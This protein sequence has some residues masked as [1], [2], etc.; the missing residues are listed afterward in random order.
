MTS[1]RHKNSVRRQL[2]LGVLATT[3]CALLITGAA[4]A[5]FDLRSFR[6]SALADLTAMGDILALA[7]TPALEF[8]DPQ[9]ASEY[10]ELLRAKPAITAAALYAPNGALFAK[11]SSGEATPDFP[12]LPGHDG[13]QVAGKEIALFKRV[14]ADG[15]IV[16]TVYVRAHYDVAGRIERYLGILAAVLLLSLAAA[17]LMSH[18]LHRGITEPI[19]GVVD[20]AR[21]VLDKRDY[22][23]RAPKGHD[24]ELGV[25]VDAF[26]NMLD[27]VGERT[28][29]LERAREELRTLNAELEQR[30]AARTAQ[31][32]TANK[33]LEGFSYSVSHDLRAPLRAV[34][35]FAELLRD[36]HA[37]QLDAEGLRKLDVIRDEAARMGTLIDDLLAFSRLGRK[38][39]QPA[40]LDM[41]D[42]VSNVVDRLRADSGGERVAFRMGRLPRAWG[43]RA[44]L[45]QVWVNLLSNAVKFS[46]KKDAPVVEVGAISAEREHVFFVRDNGAGFDP[47]YAS[48]LFGVFQRLHDGAEF[49]GTG[50]GLALVQRIV[51]RHG[52][53]VWA[54][55][56]P[57]EGATF[58]FTLPKENSHAG[59]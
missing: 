58:H 55:S 56:K 17:A 29:V 3:G 24:D 2:L 23:A 35:G 16:G 57:G 49:P 41:A 51:V 10:L 21:N 47:R 11:Y 37:A 46:S 31:L 4:V 22:S 32:E 7:S 6:D 18:R 42:L 26:N 50:V 34:G 14:I 12:E 43:D 8:D 1:T 53:R 59:V 9:T 19:R 28:A 33:E 27:E 39:L 40:E 48:K 5:Y 36:D 20:V 52:G 45:E 38:S 54:D 13:Y 15:E 44:L 25:L 30:V